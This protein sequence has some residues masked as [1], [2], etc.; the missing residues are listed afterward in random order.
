MPVINQTIM[1]S[2]EV[3]RSDVYNAMVAAKEAAKAE[4][5]AGMQRNGSFAR[6]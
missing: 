6:A 2:G 1:V 3:S 4:I 5:F